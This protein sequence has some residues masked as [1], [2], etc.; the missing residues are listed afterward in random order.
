MKLQV[1]LNRS[2]VKPIGRQYANDIKDAVP[3]GAC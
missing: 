3:A 2:D 1:K